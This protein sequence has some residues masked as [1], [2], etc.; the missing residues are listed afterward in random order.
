MYDLGILIPAIRTYRWEPLYESLKIACKDNSFQV[1][2]VSPFDLPSFFD[3]IENVKLI[4]EYGSVSRAIQKG[5][6]EVDSNL[7]FSTVDDC[8]FMEDSLD[9]GIEQ[10][11]DECGYKDVMNMRYSENGDIQPK[12][13]YAAWYNDTLRLPGISEDWQVAPQFIMNRNYFIELGGFDC[14]WEYS[15]E[16]Q[17]DLMFR[18]QKDGGTIKHS[19]VYA[20]VADW[21]QGEAGDH[22]TIHM[23]QILH[24]YPILRE[25]YM[26]KNDRIHIDYDNWKN[27][28][29]VWERRFHE[30]YETYEEMVEKRGYII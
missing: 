28:P 3:D 23:A 2:F 20:C 15:N 1:V 22:E 10:Y 14:R 30:K 24:D 27:T 18:L 8:I 21:Y 25:I 13:Y 16:P 9:C 11:K 26:Q 19:D 12:E 5:M 29:E 6:L 4:K 7:V 17:N